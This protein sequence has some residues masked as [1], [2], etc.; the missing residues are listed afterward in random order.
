MN[1]A[2]KAA[3]ASTALAAAFAATPA[4]AADLGHSYGGSIKDSPYVAPLPRVS[5]GAA[6]P[7]YVRGDVGYSISAD[8]DA[9]WPVFNETFVDSGDTNTTI[10]RHDVVYTLEGDQVS[11][12]QLDNSWVFDVGAGCGSGSRGFRG[13]IM[14]GFRGDKKFEGEPQIYNG[15][16]IGQPEATGAPAPVDD[17]M[18]TNI[19]SH[20]IMA[21]AY[22]D[23][24]QYGNFV[25]Y[26]G[27]GVGVAFHQVDEV[28][29]T[30]NPNL[31]NRI[32][33]NES[34]DFAWALM[35]GVGYQ[36][37]DNAVL[38]VGYRY[39]DMGSAKSGR[40]DNAGF[41]NPAVTYDDLAA[42]EIKV[43]L[44]YHFGGGSSC[45]DY[46]SLK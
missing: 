39:I 6:G 22:Y 10:D 42:H 29:F 3:C 26:V 15:T 24:G 9:R 32:E 8:P 14:F 2:L 1:F 19:Q 23:L 4:M 33:D 35:A 38:D 27:G 41:V 16:L 31:T 30:G 46:A 37:S 12:A 7:C 20:T 28:F 36:V 34:F 21:N 44:R 18:Q 5:G 25:P 13:E 11:G 40:V 43:G 17:P 45:C